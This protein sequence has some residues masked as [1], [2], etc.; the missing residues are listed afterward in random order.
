MAG[1]GSRNGTLNRL[2]LIRGKKVN[3]ERDGVQG[4][5]IIELTFSSHSEIDR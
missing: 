2:L 4:A 3:I 5:V 1:K